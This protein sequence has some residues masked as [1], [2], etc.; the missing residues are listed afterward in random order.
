MIK[1]DYHPYPDVKV[2][3]DRSNATI[4]VKCKNPKFKS[5]VRSVLKSLEADHGDDLLIADRVK[6]SPECRTPFW[7]LRDFAETLTKIASDC[8]T[9]ENII[10]LHTNPPLDR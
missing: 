7:L 4:Q 6:F 2:T 10:D 8:K 1:L 5:Y 9:P 3:F